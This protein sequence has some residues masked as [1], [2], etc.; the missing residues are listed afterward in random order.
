MPRRGIKSEE[1]AFVDKD[2]R[3]TEADRGR[4]RQTEADRGRQRQTEAE[5]Q[6]EQMR[7]RQEHRYMYWDTLKRR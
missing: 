5:R 3:Q 2:N 1:E 7:C 6:T 4:Q